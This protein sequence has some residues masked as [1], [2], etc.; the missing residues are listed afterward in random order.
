M[1]GKEGKTLGGDA[2]EASL[3]RAWLRIPGN[4]QGRSGTKKVRA[5]KGKGRVK[6]TR[7]WKRQ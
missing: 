6:K 2:I 4:L 7:S 5:S 1:K 3:G